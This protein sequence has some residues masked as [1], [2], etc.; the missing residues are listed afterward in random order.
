MVVLQ[1]VLVLYQ[2]IL[3]CNASSDSKEQPYESSVVQNHFSQPCWAGFS[4]GY[5]RKTD[6]T[7]AQCWSA[8][9]PH[10]RN[11]AWSFFWMPYISLNLRYTHAH[12]TIISIIISI[13]PIHHH[14]QC[15]KILATLN[16]VS[17]HLDRY[18]RLQ[19]TFIFPIRWSAMTPTSHSY[20]LARNDV[21]G[22]FFHISKKSEVLT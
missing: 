15:Y 17:R 10:G 6:R 8:P 14:H 18:R 12:I 5:S 21:M 20:G 3:Y 9:P 13:A 11:I 2:G 19:G 7:M 1:F 16:N 4:H 22:M